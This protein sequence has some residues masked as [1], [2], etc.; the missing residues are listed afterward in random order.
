MM[1]AE[2]N[3]IDQPNYQMYCDFRPDPTHNW[4]APRLQPP[5]SL[6]G[7][8]PRWR[9]RAGIW[10]SDIPSASGSSPGRCWRA[11]RRSTKGRSAPSWTWVSIPL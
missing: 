8:V 9:R 7:E 2:A 5:F 6:A 1:Q 11:L 3:E 10:C 4:P